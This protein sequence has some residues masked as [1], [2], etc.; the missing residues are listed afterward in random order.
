MPQLSGDEV[1]NTIRDRDLDC[2]VVMVTGVT[3]DFDILDLPFDVS[4][5]AVPVRAL[6]AL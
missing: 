5:T 1:L 6:S 2:Q 3:A 4:A